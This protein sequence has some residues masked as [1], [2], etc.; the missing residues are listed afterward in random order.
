MKHEISTSITIN[1]SIERVWEE[2]Y[3]FSEYPNWNPFIKAIT[4]TIALN[5]PFRAEIGTMKFSP[6]L[7]VLKPQE[8]FTWLG[9]LLF[10]RLFDGQHTFLFAAN[11]DGTTTMIQKEA[12]SGILVG[13]MKKKL[14]S[15]IIDGFK[16]MNSALKLR[17][18]R[19][20]V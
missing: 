17:C 18:E 16:S 11:G 20:T 9:K 15:E 3:T 12:F 6:V 1:A 13:M 7:K 5:Q 8:E 2:F 14:D 4:G 19:L 10:K